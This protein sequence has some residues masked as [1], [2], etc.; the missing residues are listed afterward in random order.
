MM[1]GQQGFT[2]IE[3]MVTLA[4]LATLAAAALPMVHRHQ[5]QRDENV[6]RESLRNIRIAVDRY[7][8]A[9]EAGRIDKEVNASGY[10]RT[11]QELVDGVVDKTSPTK[12]KIYF[13]RQIPRDPF[14]QCEGKPDAETWQLRASSQPPD[15]FTGGKDVY[16]IR[17]S[18][19]AIGLNGVPYA[20]W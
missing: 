13:L 8:Q 17:S 11:L 3:M 19:N 7:A 6:L 15:E 4:L 12:K 10:P 18:S 14:C 1:R 5:L 20:K 9:S 16:D 2:L